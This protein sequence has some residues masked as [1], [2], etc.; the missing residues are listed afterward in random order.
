MVKIIA[1]RGFAKINK[2]NTVPAFEYAAKSGCYGIEADIH[3]TSDNYFVMF[4]DKKTTRL[5]G[6]YKVLAKSDL[7]TIQKIKVPYRT[8]R[9]R[10]PMLSE[11]LAICKSGNKKAVMELKCE[12]TDKQLQLLVNLVKSEFSV[13]ESIFI[14]FDAEVLKR[15]R[16]HFPKVPCQYVR[17]D[18]NDSDFEILV[19]NKF[20]LDVYYKNITEEL[21]KKCH[22]AGIKVNCWTVNKKRVIKRLQQIGVDYITSD[23]VWDTK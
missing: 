15:L 18:F 6:H 1:H 12:L 20:D 10:I 23:K 16:T 5:G 8:K 13:D 22:S 4:H 19:N 11:Y 7:E 14:S 17:R 3:V 9:L 2:Q 21:V